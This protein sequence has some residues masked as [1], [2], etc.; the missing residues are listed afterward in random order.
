MKHPL[1]KKGELKDLKLGQYYIIRYNGYDT[2]YE[3]VIDNM[4]Y[5]IYILSKIKYIDEEKNKIVY[6]EKGTI[7]SYSGVDIYSVL[8]PT[9][10]SII[11]DFILWDSIREELE[12]KNPISYHNYTTDDEVDRS[13]LIDHETYNKFRRVK[14]EQLGR[15]D[16]KYKDLKIGDKFIHTKE[17]G[18]GYF[19]VGEEYHITNIN[20]KNNRISMNVT[21]GE[22]GVTNRELRDKYVN[23]SIE[24]INDNFIIS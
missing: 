10:Q 22:T 5:G 23:I 4:K 2:D 9:D 12:E 13:I 7:E 21:F 15:S 16:L 8:I 14:N 19:I 3:C 6:G 11:D 20:K 17:N 1:F 24:V 18:Y